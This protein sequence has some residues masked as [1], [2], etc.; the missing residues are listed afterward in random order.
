MYARANVCAC[1]CVC[2]CVC[3]SVCVCL[4]LCLCL[5]VSVWEAGVLKANWPTDPIPDGSV[6][7]AASLIN[8]SNAPPPLQHHRQLP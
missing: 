8:V 6:R 4:C 5:C 7:E 3:V 1:A 2:A